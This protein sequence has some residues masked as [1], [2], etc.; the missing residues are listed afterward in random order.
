MSTS[1]G[2]SGPTGA[3]R[4]RR[5]RRASAGGAGHPGA[6]A[7]TTPLLLRVAACGVCRTDLHLA[8]GDLPPH[9][10]NC[11]PG[12][13]WS[14]MWLWRRRSR[15]LCA[16]E[17]AASPGSRGTCGECEY[18]LRGSE[19]LCQP[20]TYTGWDVDG[21]YAPYLTVDA[22]TP[23]ACPTAFRR[24]ARA[25]AVRRDHRLPRP[26]RAELPPGVASASTA[27]AAPRTW[28]GS[29]PWLRGDVYVITRG[30]ARNWPG[31]RRRL[32]P[33]ARDTPPE[34]LD[35]AILFAPVGDLVPPALA[36]LA[37][38]DARDR[39]D[40]PERH[41]GPG[42]RRY[43]FQER[44]S[45]RHREHPQDGREFLDVRRRARAVAH[46]LRVP[47]RRRRP[48]PGRPQGGPF[49]RRR[50]PHPLAG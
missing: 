10:E 31:T 11:V 12:T 22:V 25:A 43:L 47:A 18:C 17:R 42:L 39:R 49:R 32:R 19:N 3:R 4:D 34:P 14:A 7:G 29:W 16:R 21:G 38:R 35:G 6:R 13:R 40:L 48:R 15:R 2:R 23:T 36:A 24:R 1:L 50:R 27:S 9:R 46:H 20:S 41:P 30:R 44:R 8:E 26:K 5:G 45:Q 37:R 28:P 33:A